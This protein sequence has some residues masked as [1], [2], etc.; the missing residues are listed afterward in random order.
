MLCG[1]DGALPWQQV[2]ALGV[3]GVTS[4]VGCALKGRGVQQQD[5]RSQSASLLS[6]SLFSLSKKERM[7][8]RAALMLAALLAA[9][10]LCCPRGAASAAPEHDRPKRSMGK[11][12]KLFLF[13]SFF[14]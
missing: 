6:S 12:R 9:A 7:Q 4:R 11:I 1:A 3:G 8:K 10:A 5:K 14:I 2:C 13:I